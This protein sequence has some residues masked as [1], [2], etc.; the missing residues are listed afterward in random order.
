MQHRP[1]LATLSLALALTACGDDKPGMMNTTKDMTGSTGAS[2]GMSVTGT[3]ETSTTANVTTGPETSAG[4]SGGATESFIM[5]KDA[6]GSKPPECDV[7]EQDCPAGKA[8]K[9]AASPGAD[10]WDTAVCTEV[11]ANP[12]AVGDPCT[13][14]GQ[15]GVD[16]CD[17]GNLCWYFDGMGNGS[18]I[19]MCT[20]SAMNP[21]CEAG[22]VCDITN[23]GQLIL[24]LQVCDPLAQSCPDGQICFFSDTAS[25]FICDFDA[26][27]DMGMY[28]DPC[29]YINVCDYGLF[30]T[31]AKNVPGCV[32]SGCCSPYCDVTLPN[33]CPDQAKGQV[34]V[35]WYTMNPPPGQEN[36][37]ACA[38]P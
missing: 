27:G 30:C 25:N 19:A 34:C 12:G 29:E 33:D 17:V 20:G 22:L 18:C 24:C 28:G 5:A 26:S 9:P 23:N 37:G 10:T 35:P 6:G 2:E 31:D 1:T 3:P 21:T 14:D 8:C 15:T 16:T 13:A 4:S 38:I 32:S 36:I 7:F 11:G